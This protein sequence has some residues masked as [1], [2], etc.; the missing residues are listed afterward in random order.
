MTL[1]PYNNLS[2]IIQG[3]AST[4]LIKKWWIYQVIHMQYIFKL[5]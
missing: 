1:R 4:R 3:S 2:S 5:I